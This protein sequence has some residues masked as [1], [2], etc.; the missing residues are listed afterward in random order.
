MIRLSCNRRS[1]GGITTTRL[2]RLIAVLMFGLSF[3]AGRGRPVGV[4]SSAA[5]D[6]PSPSEAKLLTLANAIPSKANRMATFI[7]GMDGDSAD[8]LVSLR[9]HSEWKAFKARTDSQWAA[10]SDTLEKIRRWAN[11]EFPDQVESD[12]D[13]FY[14]FGGPDFL[15][16]NTVYPNASRYVLFGLEY[17]GLIPDPADIPADSLQYFLW[18][19]N[20]SLSGMLRLK[21]FVTKD[22]IKDLRREYLQ[23]T[24]PILMYFMARTGHR[25]ISIQPVRIDS[26][27]TI[28]YADAWSGKRR[29][30]TGVEFLFRKNDSIRIQKLTYVS[31]DVSDDALK[32]NPNASRF[33]ANLESD[34]TTYIK[35]ASYL[36]HREG[37]VA[38]RETILSKSASILEDDSSIPFKY[39]TPAIWKVTLYG[40]YVKP[41]DS[42]WECFQPDLYAAYLKGS[43]QI[44]FDLG[45]GKAT[46]LLSAARKQAGK[47]SPSQKKGNSRIHT[48]G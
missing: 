10:L 4:P 36:M 37:F 33:L 29:Y 46:N 17:P 6:E 19:L 7:A 22:M 18:E 20:K 24:I 38:I 16:V 42:F 41:I 27:G 30:N 47:V 45:Y 35:A 12:R 39:F 5:L 28:V 3:L 2:V 40:D 44:D 32:R 25:I 48:G 9:N 1:L 21:F 13:V 31:I 34:A 8:G 26:N 15:Y 43:K 11:A 23:G 14:P